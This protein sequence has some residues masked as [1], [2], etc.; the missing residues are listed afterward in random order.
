[1]DWWI[2]NWWCL[3]AGDIR[4]LPAD[5]ARRYFMGLKAED[6]AADDAEAAAAVREAA[7]YRPI[8]RRLR[9][10]YET[11]HPD[12]LAAGLGAIHSACGALRCARARRRCL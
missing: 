11:Q 3:P 2:A 9:D 8:V 12:K 5:T 10:F 1:M 6:Y 7:E 4:A